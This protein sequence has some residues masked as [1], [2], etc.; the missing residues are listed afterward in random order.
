M[1]SV[2]SSHVLIILAWSECTHPSAWAPGRAA[3]MKFAWRWGKDSRKFR[4]MRAK[5]W[6]HD[7]RSRLSIFRDH[8][9]AS[10]THTNSHLLIPSQ[11]RN[12]KHLEKRR[13]SEQNTSE[14]KISKTLT[15]VVLRLQ[16][17]P[18]PLAWH[19]ASYRSYL[20]F[21]R[22]SL[23]SDGWMKSYDRKREIIFG[24]YSSPLV[25]AR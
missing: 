18:R 2:S 20:H 21:G 1:I 9:C 3:E 10:F 11:S 23:K 7:F 25:C 8:G 16:N 5:H 17:F 12:R 13:A 22:F 24:K 6:S 15:T 14:R 19:V 4:V